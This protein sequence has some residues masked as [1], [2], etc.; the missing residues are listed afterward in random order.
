MQSWTIMENDGT[1]RYDI[2]V[3]D[4]VIVCGQ[5]SLKT[6]NVALANQSSPTLET[7]PGRKG[8]PVFKK[9]RSVFRKNVHFSEIRTKTR[10]SSSLIC[11]VE[12]GGGLFVVTH[13]ASQASRAEP[14]RAGAV[15]NRAE[16]C[17]LSAKSETQ[18]IH[19]L[20]NFYEITHKFSRGPFDDG[21]SSTFHR[22]LACAILSNPNISKTAVDRKC[23]ILFSV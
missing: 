8:R 5:Y 7:K 21:E 9:F 10:N 1:N 4:D 22:L 20:N 16:L 17:Q 6:C 18:N 23:C 19:F 15:P 3:D 11:M 13:C 14:S 2:S 12:V